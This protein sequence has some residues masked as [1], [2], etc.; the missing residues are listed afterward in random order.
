[1]AET[2]VM[3][4]RDFGDRTDRKHARLKYTIADRGI[5]WFKDELF[6]RLG[7]ELEPPRAFE[8]TTQG[9]RFGWLRG[10]DGRWHLTL[11][12]ESGRV[13]DRPGATHLTGL[14]K[15]ARI[16]PGRFP[17]HAEPEPDHRQRAAGRLHEDRPD[18][19]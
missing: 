11:R 3:I 7:F 13:A 10:H 17:A 19:P 9:D 12:I 1:M 8:F 15:I 6:R 14:E 4:Q 5:D 18:R 2:V 16:P